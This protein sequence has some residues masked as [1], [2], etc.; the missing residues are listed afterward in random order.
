MGEDMPR[1]PFCT[2]QQGIGGS[3]NGGGSAGLPPSNPPDQQNWKPPPVSPDVGKCLAEAWVKCLDEL[4][5][6]TPLDFLKCL[7]KECLQSALL[8]SFCTGGCWSHMPDGDCKDLVVECC[9][10]YLCSDEFGTKDIGDCFVNGPYDDWQSE[11]NWDFDKGVDCL[12]QILDAYVQC[13]AE[14]ENP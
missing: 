10:R 4:I 14:E 2:S 12:Q 6:S 7:M 1:N 11:H 5:K 9:N 8:S 13:F 3:G